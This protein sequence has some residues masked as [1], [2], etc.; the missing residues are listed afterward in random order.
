[1]LE[2]QRAQV[3]VVVEIIVERRRPDLERQ[4][5]PWHRKSQPVG[6]LAAA[7]PAW[8]LSAS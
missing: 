6:S 8:H 1:M 2:P 7:V 5:K 4:V 3:P